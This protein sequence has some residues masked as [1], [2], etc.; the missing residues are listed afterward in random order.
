MEVVM[1]AYVEESAMAYGAENP[2]WTVTYLENVSG[3]EIA[4][5][6]RAA[7]YQQTINRATD[8]LNTDFSKSEGSYCFNQFARESPPFRAGR[9]SAAA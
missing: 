4:I 6:V 5:E 9:D 7:E 3:N 2:M 1:S 8:R